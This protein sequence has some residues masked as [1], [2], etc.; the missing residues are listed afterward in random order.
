M[1]CSW[2]QASLITGEYENR[3]EKSLNMLKH[4]VMMKLLVVVAVIV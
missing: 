4:L 3:L 2:M 1:D